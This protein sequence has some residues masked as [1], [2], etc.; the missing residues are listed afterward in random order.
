MDRVKN[1][2]S[3]RDSRTATS[4]PNKHNAT[5]RQHIPKMK[6]S[7]KNW[8]EQDAGLRRRGS[9]TLSPVACAVSS[10]FDAGCECAG[11]ASV[12]PP[13][14]LV[15]KAYE[16]DPHILQSIGKANRCVMRIANSCS[17]RNRVY[18]TGSRRS[19]RTSFA[20]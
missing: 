11:T 15:S 18:S 3:W 13:V 17:T 2:C 5:R 10:P 6:F 20:L 19:T 12:I 1:G 8:A 4:M 7:V 9:L 16:I 14:G